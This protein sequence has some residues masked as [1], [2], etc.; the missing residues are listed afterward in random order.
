[1]RV[2]ITYL[3]FHTNKIQFDLEEASHYKIDKTF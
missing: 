2:Y 1:M 3:H